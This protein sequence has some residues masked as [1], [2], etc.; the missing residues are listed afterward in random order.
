MR[1]KPT[2]Y[3]QGTNCD[4]LSSRNHLPHKLPNNIMAIII[5]IKSIITNNLLRVE[6]PRT[7][8]ITHIYKNDKIETYIYYKINLCA[9]Y[10]ISRVNTMPVLSF[11]NHNKI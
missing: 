4:P 3:Y 7:Q 6:H 9:T 1:L 2:Y 11:N 5:A 10:I 8:T